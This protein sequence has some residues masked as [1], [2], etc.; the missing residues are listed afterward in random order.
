MKL[1]IA[2]LMMSFSLL[3][4]AGH[5]ENFSLMSKEEQNSFI[6]EEAKQERRSFWQA[7]H[8]DVSSSFSLVDKEFLDD[9]VRKYNN[10]RYETPLDSDEISDLYR[11]FY[12]KTCQLYHIGVSSNYWGGYGET[13]I[14]VL[15]YT[16]TKK[17]WS[18][19]HTI[20]AE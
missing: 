5:N 10:D 14:F 11:C 9:Y 13:G 8:A 12:G 17:S 6:A 3:A 18:I 15:L 16:K 4:F 1:V 20:Y 7:G 2:L 19:R